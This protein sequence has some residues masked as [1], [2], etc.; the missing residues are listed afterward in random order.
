MGKMAIE[1]NDFL[2]KMTPDEKNYLWEKFPMD[3]KL[4]YVSEE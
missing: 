3:N 4:S 2:G 1:K